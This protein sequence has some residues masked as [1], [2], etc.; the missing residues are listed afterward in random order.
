MNDFIVQLIA[1]LD[2]SKTANDVKE[3]EKQLESKGI[4][5]KPVLDISASKQETANF[6]KQM[7]SVLKTVGLDL[8]TSTIRTALNQVIKDINSVTSQANKIQLSIDNGDFEP[9]ILGYQTSLQK[10]GLSADEV[11]SHMKGVNTALENLKTS[12]T[13]INIVPD[14]VVANAKTLD[15]E[16]LKLSNTVKQIRLK[17]SLNADDL[18]VESTI[19]RLNEQLRKNSAYS[20]DSKKQI[21]EWIAELEKGNVAEAR[22]KQINVEAKLLHSNMARLNKIGFS[23]VD[24]LKQ[25]WEKFGGWSIATGIMMKGVYEFKDALSEL[26]EVD[27]YLTEISKANDS[28]SKSELAQIGIDA[29]DVASKYGKNATD[30][31]SGVQEMSR[32]GYDNAASM[33]ELSTAVQGAGDMTDDLANSYI[34]ATDKAYGLNGSIQA[35]TKTLDGANNITNNNAVN[36]TELA[37]GMKVVGSQ[38][39]SSQMAIEETTAVIG[40]LVAVTQQSGSEMGN[41]F[42]GILMNLQQVTGEIEDGGDA[43]DETSLT[44][45]EKACEELGVSLSTVKDGVVSLKEPMQILKELSEEYTKLDESDARRT[46]L[47]SAVG[48]KYRANALNA[49]LEN[50]DLYEKMLQDYADGE[51]SMAREAEK[52][53][54]SWE[55]SLNRLGNSWTKFIDSLTNQ[56]AIIGATNALS[57]LLNGITSITDKI[58]VLSTAGLG[59]GAILGGKNVGK[60]NYISNLQTSLSIV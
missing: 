7:Q 28:L 52:T 1:K 23:W 58:G 25:T 42:K 20:K 44:K 60:E 16:M 48:G 32:A 35:L 34:I 27:T 38:A 30:Y 10:L 50:Y 51:G 2:T 24:K 53:A 47:L 14:D 12:A 54:K 41:A 3:L 29:F 22:L 57:N 19:A 43:I 55:G 6:V 56:D 36:M 46:N 11:S 15:N 21:R 39:A 13:G 5:L 4:K 17:D 37:E 49:I 18:K 26:K 8:D 40:T 45:Y 59:I 9:K 33:A 31:L